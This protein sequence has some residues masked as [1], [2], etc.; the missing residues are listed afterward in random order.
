MKDRANSINT[1]KAV[2]RNVLDSEAP[3]NINNAVDRDIIP[4]G[5]DAGLRI[6]ENV[7]SV[8]GAVLEFVP[9]K[10]IEHEPVRRD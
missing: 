2:Y 1:H 6:T 9:D 10:H 8:G 7:M 3:T 5:D 4:Y